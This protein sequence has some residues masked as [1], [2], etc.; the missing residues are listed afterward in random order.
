MNKIKKRFLSGLFAFG[1][2][3]SMYSPS[4][5]YASNDSNGYTVQPRINVTTVVKSFETVY[6]RS[7]FTKLYNENYVYMDLQYVNS[8]SRTSK[9]VG[10]TT[11]SDSLKGYVR[12]KTIY[13]YKSK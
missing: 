13:T 4:V 3:L 8:Y 12:Y 6:N 7:P 11:I 5:I 10:A 1:M 2:A 9:E